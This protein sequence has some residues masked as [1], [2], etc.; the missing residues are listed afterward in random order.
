M[1]HW[2]SAWA[3]FSTPLLHEPNYNYV[4]LDCRGQ[5]IL[6]PK[7][8]I[9]SQTPI[10]CRIYDTRQTTQILVVTSLSKGLTVAE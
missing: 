10:I 5:R 6:V 2:D 1:L 3:K 8:N 7:T 4:E 9:N